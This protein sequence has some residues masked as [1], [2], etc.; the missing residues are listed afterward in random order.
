VGVD[1]R[2]LGYMIRE[3]IKRDKLRIKAGK[4]VWE[5]EK[6]LDQGNSGELMRSCRRMMRG[7]GQRGI[8]VEKGEGKIF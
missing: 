7:R 2:T 4:R 8:K 1:W 3:E 5:F 6:K